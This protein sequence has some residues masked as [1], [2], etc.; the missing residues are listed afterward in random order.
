MRLVCVFMVVVAATPLAAEAQIYAWR[1]K[2]G[3]LVLSDR[4]LDSS[5][6]TY[7]VPS[8]AGLRTTR[9]ALVPNVYDD[10]VARHATRERVR[11]DLVRAVIQ[12]ESGFNRWAVS[13]KG[14]MGLMQLMPGTASE[15]GVR[16][17]FDPAE[18][19][20]G[21]VTYLRTLLDRYAGNEELALAAY[22]AGPAAVAR[23]GDKVPPYAETQRYVS[24]IRARTSLAATAGPSN[25]IYKTVDE[26]NGRQVPR[27]SNVKPA[28]REHAVVRT[29]QPVTP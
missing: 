9:P 29:R 19:I 21:G 8:A 17:P 13:P 25:R 28:G 22:N 20:R 16:N 7:S 26:V 1:A 15:L 11:S 5:A 10:L 12:A 4:P 6:R 2:N 24:R 14:A 27:Y 18:N 3:T 23:Y